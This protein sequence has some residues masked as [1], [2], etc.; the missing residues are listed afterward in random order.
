LQQQCRGVEFLPATAYS[1]DDARKI[2][3][4]D[5][6]ADGYVAYMIGGWARAGERN[7]FSGS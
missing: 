4:D 5:A 3:Q 7:W 2:L 6:A 1:P